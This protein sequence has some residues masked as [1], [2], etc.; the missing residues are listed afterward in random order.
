MN[1]RIK[2]LFLFV[3]TLT[4]VN[5]FTQIVTDK[6][7]VFLFTDRDYCISG[8]TLWFK[9]WLPQILEEKSN[10][11]HVQLD[12]KTGNVISSV[13]KQSNKGWAQGFIH[14]PDSLSSGLCFVT[15]FLN[16]QRDSLKKEIVSNALY[17]YNRFE[18]SITELDFVNSELK[19]NKVNVDLEVKIATDKTNYQPRDKVN[20]HIT[21]NSNKISKAVIKARLI[22][23]FTYENGGTYKFDYISSNTSIPVFAEKDGV[24]ISG[25]VYNKEKN[26]EHRALVILS[27]TDDPPYFD[28]SVTGKQGDFH[29]YL[30][31]AIGIAPV[32]IQAISSSSEEFLI[33]TE[34]NSLERIERS[35][36]QTK[37]LTPEQSE[38]ISSIIE[39]SFIKKLF[40]PR[41]TSLRDTFSMPL[42]YELPFY[43]PP[44]TR[45]VP[46]E[47]FDL[48]DF[49]EISRELL[50]G[51]QY[52][53]R[54]GTV[55]FRMLNTTMNT[56]F[57]NEPLRMINGIPVFK[58]NLF[59]PLKSNDI[60][61]IDLVQSE[62]VYGD[63]Q[64]KG[65]LAV[66]L[67]D[68]S[69]SW[70]AQQPNIYQFNLPCLQPDGSPG[71]L[72]TKE[73]AFS[74]PDTRQIYLW[75]ILDEKGGKDIQF[76]LSDMKGKVEISV[77]GVTTTNRPFKTSKIIEVK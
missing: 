46:A 19:E 50:P 42:K 60:N 74:T 67:H 64:F 37:T 48:P 13:A 20:L 5:G 45:V 40:N 73:V 53:E 47:Y 29:F 34:Q 18:E 43:G 1:N 22:D 65:I 28:Y 10:V 2:I 7:K 70:M 25:K 8:D 54:N 63:L 68:E 6:D 12:T 27:I 14:V 44:T 11:V 49:Q 72:K 26:P 58:N 3:L 76:N 51:L 21:A 36:F 35:K 77:E 59:K 30:K 24:I 62:R 66:A 9:V 15:A 32:V 55:S 75:D 38:F 23:P 31:N 56:F 33:H 39:G 17:V 71:Y 16:V 4:I 69:N 57:G 52:R 41:F 61:Y